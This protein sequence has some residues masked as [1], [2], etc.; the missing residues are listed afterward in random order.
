MPKLECWTWLTPVFQHICLVAIYS[1]LIMTRGLLLSFELD[2][3]GH[4]L[5]HPIL[6]YSFSM[7]IEITTWKKM[8][9]CKINKCKPC[10]VHVSDENVRSKGLIVQQRH[11]VNV[12]LRDL[13]TCH[14]FL[15]IAFRIKSNVG[16]WPALIKPHSENILHSTHDQTIMKQCIQDKKIIP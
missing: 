14:Y 4:P 1:C 13:I 11:R 2:F 3:P 6:N 5:V 9:K 7:Y 8:N 12:T 16:S 10:M 15:T